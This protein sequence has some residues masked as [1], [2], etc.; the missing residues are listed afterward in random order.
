VHPEGV[1]RLGTLGLAGPASEQFCSL[2]AAAGTSQTRA[3]PNLLPAA[4]VCEEAIMQSRDLRKLAQ[5]CQAKARAALGP[6]ARKTYLGA[7]NL[8]TQ[9]AEHSEAL[10]AKL[11]PFALPEA[12]NS[13]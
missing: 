11:P 2:C 7:A 1:E 8:W 9:L 13:N 6:E 3:G 10:D 4:L 5:E 12:A